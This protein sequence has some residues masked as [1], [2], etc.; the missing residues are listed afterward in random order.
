[1]AKPELFCS[2]AVDQ[3]IELNFADL[4]A[5]SDA[6]STGNGDVEPVIWMLSIRLFPLE[7]VDPLNV[8]LTNAFVTPPRPDPPEFGS[9]VITPEVV[10]LDEM[11]PDV[12][13][14]LT[15]AIEFQLEPPSA[16]YSQTFEVNPVV[17][18]WAV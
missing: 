16:L 4:V 7:L 17:V 18:L 15:D 2:E 13:P 6:S 12:V 11:V 14:L 5:L 8:T 10:K 3:F 9:I 1:M